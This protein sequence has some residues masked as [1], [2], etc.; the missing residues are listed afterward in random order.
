MGLGKRRASRQQEL[1]IAAD[2]LSRTPRHVFY[3]KL[4]RLLAKARFDAWIEERCR[5]YYAEEGR[6]SIPPGVY[7]RMVLVGYFEGIDSQRGI[8]WRCADS[9]SLQVFLGYGP[10]EETPDH[11]SLTKI[12][13]RLPVEL[14]AEV[15]QFVLALVEK[16]KLLSATVVGVDST[17]LEANAA[18]KSIVRKDTGEN[19]NQYV[20]RL[21]QEEGVIGPEEEPTQEELR[22]YDR[23]RKDKKVSNDEW[24]NPHDSEAKIAKMKDGRTHLAYKA[25]HVVDLKTEAIL[26]AE[27]YGADEADTATLVPSLE[28]AQA[29]VDSTESGRT[30]EKAAADKGYHAADTLVAC[31]ELGLYGV[32]TYIPEPRGRRRWTDKTAEQQ[33]AVLGNRARTQRAYGKRLQRRRS[34]LVERSFAHVCDTGGSRRTWLRGLENVRK[35]HLLAAAAHNL[36]LILRKLLGA[37]KPRAFE[38]LLRALKSLY[39]AQLTL[40]LTLSTLHAAK[41]WRRLPSVVALR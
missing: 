13:Q 26:A 36:G 9:R 25:E 34:E 37:G 18:M 19:W 22:R 27:I 16:H 8:A 10:T 41:L 21:M 7:F 35:R 24:E 33:A 4:N 32:K 12:R 6:R 39:F 20:T 40:R 14:Y 29:N 38:D 23:K 1:W 2:R 30:I 31:Q 11:S 3:E 28:Q 5:P 15:F 17:A